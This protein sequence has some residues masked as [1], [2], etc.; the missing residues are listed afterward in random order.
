MERLPLNS[1]FGFFRWSMIMVF[2]FSVV[3]PMRARPNGTFNAATASETVAA[4]S[5]GTTPC[6]LFLQKAS[7][8]TG[9]NNGENG[10]QGHMSWHQPLLAYCLRTTQVLFPLLML[11]NLFEIKGIMARLFLAQ[12]SICNPATSSSTF[13]VLDSFHSFHSPLANISSQKGRP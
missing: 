9:W 3:S 5:M 6:P 2:L 8:I 1:H 13:W 12:W 10:T 4:F 7:R 11:R